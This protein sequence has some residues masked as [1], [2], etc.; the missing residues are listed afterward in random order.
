MKTAGLFCFRKGVPG[1]LID[2]GFRRF[3]F[4]FELMAHTGTSLSALRQSATL[5]HVLPLAVFMAFTALPGLFQINNPE[6]PWYRQAPEHWVYP[7][8]TV[9]VAG[10][11]LWFGTSG[12]GHYRFKPWR[13]LGLAVLLGAVGIALWIAPAWLLPWFTKGGAAVPSWAEWLGVV[14]RQEGFDPSLLAAWPGWEAAA[15]GMRFMRMVVI[16]PL[17]EELFWRAFLMRY[18]AA[19][20]GNWQRVPFGR[21]SWH[22]YGIVTALV[23]VAHN[24]ADYFGAFIWGSL[25]YFLAVRSRSLGACVVMHAVGNLLLGLYVMQTRQWGFW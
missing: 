14:E 17:V 9:L 16:V 25:M 10:L 4:L 11:L 20:D 24:P 6:L 13:G 8:Q 1:S 22:I 3:F 23:V 2:A 5:A 7:L 12:A 15:I 18:L 19:P 21:H